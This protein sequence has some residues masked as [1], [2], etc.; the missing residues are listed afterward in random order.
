MNA[1]TR[2]PIAA[3]AYVVEAL[4]RLPGSARLRPFVPWIGR[5]LL[6]GAFAA[7]IVWMGTKTPQRISIADLAAN[8]L[9]PMQSWI[10]VSGDLTEEA[11]LDPS[12]FAYRLVDPSTPG[13]SIIV[14][15]ERPLATG[16]VTISGL[17]Q[18]GRVDPSLLNGPWVGTLTADARLAHEIP[19]PWL[20][21]ALGLAA[22]LV[23]AARRTTY[24][25]F[26]RRPAGA[27]PATRAP[28]RATLWQYGDP[29]DRPRGTPAMATFG[30]TDRPAIELRTEGAA[31]RTVRLHSEYTG[32][33]A[34]ILR[35]LT[36]SAPA[37]S[38]RLP[39]EDVTIAF[40]SAQDRDAVFGVLQARARE[41]TGRPSVLPE[42]TRTRQTD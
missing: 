13:P 34:G 1:L 5:L 15:S 20:A 19:P 23:I 14:L 17:L 32:S 18:G 24:P 33:A 40:A 2:V 26:F 4:R 30:S 11:S 42:A 3:F 9:S 21:A 6:A 39:A 38:L 41:L 7:L 12:S 29:G 35:G 27:A 31:P 36:W 25:M 22:V 8:R 16:W 28:I 37:I 10:I